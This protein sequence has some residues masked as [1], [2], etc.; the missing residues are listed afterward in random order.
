MASAPQPVRARRATLATS[1]KASL[2]G[3]AVVAG[4]LDFGCAATMLTRKLH[5]T[6][7]KRIAGQSAT[8][9]LKPRKHARPAEAAERK[10]ARLVRAARNGCGRSPEVLGSNDSGRRT[11][12]IRNPIGRAR[13]TRWKWRSGRRSFSACTNPAS[14]AI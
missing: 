6:S 10:T 13:R 4:A 12:G 7:K 11:P 2:A 8:S 9:A 3:A 14:Q 1:L 5:L